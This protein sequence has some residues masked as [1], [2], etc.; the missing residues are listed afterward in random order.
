MIMMMVMILV[1]VVSMSP[2]HDGSSIKPYY[3]QS[4]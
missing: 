4:K 2:H 1:A 3:Q